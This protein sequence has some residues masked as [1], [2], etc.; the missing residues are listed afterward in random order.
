MKAAIPTVFLVD[1]DA[2]VL[3]SLSRLVRH[4]GYQPQTFASAEA[5][6]DMQSGPLLE[7]AC[8]V[9]DLSMPGLGGLE[10]Q[11]KLSANGF[12]CPVIFVSGNGSIPM[13]VQAMKQGAVTFLS[14][15]F[16]QDDLLEAIGEALEQHRAS[17]T[18]GFHAQEMMERIAS[19]TDRER[20]VMAWVIT[21]ALNK[22]IASRLAIAEKTVKVHRGRAMAKMR[23]MS[24]AELVRF[25]DFAGFPAARA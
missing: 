23:A 22:Q 4:A 16:D 3:R 24:V 13:T 7:P 2:S 17:L 1:D 18:A 15:P 25:C 14:K 19:L 11:N 9:L 10:L 20:E 8:L 5:F 21:G 12:T 6:L